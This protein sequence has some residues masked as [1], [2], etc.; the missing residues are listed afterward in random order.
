M[1]EES[2]HILSLILRQAWDMSNT[3]EEVSQL[4][5]WQRQSPYHMILTERFA[6]LGWINGNLTYIHDFPKEL[7]RQRIMTAID[8]QHKDKQTTSNETFYPVS[9][10]SI[11]LRVH[12]YWRTAFIAIFILSKILLVLSVYLFIKYRHLEKIAAPCIEANLHTTK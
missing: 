10:K 9:N 2:N 4:N 3:D 12:K 5:T 7:V 11:T 6:D 1:K 8:E